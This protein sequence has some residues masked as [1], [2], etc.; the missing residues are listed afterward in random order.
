MFM[1]ISIFKVLPGDQNPSEI[2]SNGC[3][4][5]KMPIFLAHDLLKTLNIILILHS[6]FNIL[7]TFIVLSISQS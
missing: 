1:M 2:H 5:C 6:K 4:V 7:L 3:A